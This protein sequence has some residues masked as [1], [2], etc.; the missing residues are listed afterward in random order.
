LGN[1]IGDQLACDAEPI[2]KCRPTFIITVLVDSDAKTHTNNEQMCFWLLNYSTSMYWKI[3][4]AFHFMVVC[5]M[6]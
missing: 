4:Y 1:A 3:G 2:C 5:S 6:M